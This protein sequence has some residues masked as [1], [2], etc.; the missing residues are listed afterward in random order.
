MMIAVVLFSISAAYAGFASGPAQYLFTKEEQTEWKSVR[1]DDEAKAFVERFWARRDPTPGTPAS[2]L[3]TSNSAKS[4]SVIRSTVPSSASSVNSKISLRRPV[5][6]DSSGGSV[7]GGSC[8][9]WFMRS[10]TSCLDR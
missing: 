2:R 6:L 10:A 5:R 9:D 1:T 7:P 4:R 3:R 8:D